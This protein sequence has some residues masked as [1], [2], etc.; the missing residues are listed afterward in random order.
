MLSVVRPGF[1][2]GLSSA[3]TSDK[4][5]Q[6]ALQMLAVLSMQRGKFGFVDAGGNRLDGDRKLQAELTV[7]AGK[8]VYDLN[9]ISARELKSGQVNYKK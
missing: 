4:Y 8:I 5:R 1:Q 7:R 2:P 9:G 3:K 6:A